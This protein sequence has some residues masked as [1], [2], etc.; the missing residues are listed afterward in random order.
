MFRRSFCI[1]GIR[2][3]IVSDEELEITDE[4]L[5]FLYDASEPA[6]TTVYL[7]AAEALPKP[8]ADGVWDSGRCF[9]GDTVFL[10]NGE[11]HPP[12]AM[13]TYV[14]DRE[15][16]IDYL[17]QSGAEIWKTAGL[18]SSLGLER[19]LLGHDALILHAS[20]IVWDGSGIL[21][22]APSGTGKSTQAE[23]WRQH[24][25]ADILNGD[26]AC[27]RKISEGYLAYGIPYAGSSNI[28][29]N[30][31]APIKAI[32][33]LRQAKENRV[34]LLR[35]GECLAYLLPELSLHRWDA[36][37]MIRALDRVADILEH[38][39]V[40]RLDCLPNADAVEV[41]RSALFNG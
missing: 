8:P 37:F 32:V 28:Y 2:V 22:T 1:A 4:S 13:V 14:E 24:A 36:Q 20:F 35:K 41:L 16:H 19:V 23:L 9:D 25:G 38:V 15:I 11:T 18:V 12:Y 40:Y 29:R 33:V 5:P 3:Q 30:E 39:L 10:C 26:R 34:Q 31:F 7:R 17:P 21:F 6:E 27:I